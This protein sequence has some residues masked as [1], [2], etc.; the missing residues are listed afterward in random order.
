[1]RLRV[2]VAVEGEHAGRIEAHLYK[3]VHVNGVKTEWAVAS[4]E[5][6]R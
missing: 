4:P 2:T 1:M 3:L 6:K 5:G